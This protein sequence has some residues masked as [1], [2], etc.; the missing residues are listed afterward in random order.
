MA[1]LDGLIG[2]LLRFELPPPLPP[3]RGGAGRLVDKFFNGLEI[4]Q[5]SNRNERVVIGTRHD[6][7]FLALS[8]AFGIECFRL[9]E[10]DQ[11]IVLPM[12]NKGGLGKSTYFAAVVKG[13]FF[14]NPHL[15]TLLYDAGRSRDR[16]FLCPLDI[17]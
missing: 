6:L 10:G 12:E 4:K 5:T 11:L 13:L 17:V 3:I 14:G 7:Q 16:R 15:L 8:A 2:H 9:P 1:L